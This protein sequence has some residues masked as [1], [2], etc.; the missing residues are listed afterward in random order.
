M[1]LLRRVAVAT[2]Q[3]VRDTFREWFEDDAPMF[4]AAGEPKDRLPFADTLCKRS[5]SPADAAGPDPAANS[6]V[7]L[8]AAMTRRAIPKE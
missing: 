6:W 3:V 7:V 2:W 5:T 4:G 8:T 1:P